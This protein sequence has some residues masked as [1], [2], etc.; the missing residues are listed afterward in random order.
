MFREG[1]LFQNL[2]QKCCTRI[3]KFLLAVREIN[4]SEPGYSKIKSTLMAHLITSPWL[5]KQMPYS[6]VYRSDFDQKF[7]S[8][9]TS[10]SY[11]PPFPGKLDQKLDFDNPYYASTYRADFSK[12]LTLPKT[13]NNQK[14]TRNWAYI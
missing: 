3:L 8:S 14:Y 5:A 10:I 13:F 9:Q 4:I 12:E 2:Y 7:P 1:V 6:S 11:L